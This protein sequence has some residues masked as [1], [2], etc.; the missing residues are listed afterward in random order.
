M[1]IAVALLL[2]VAC[3][4]VAGLML[5][6]GL[7]RDREIAIRIAIGAA[8]ARII[9]QILCESVPLSLVGGASDSCWL[10]WPGRWSACSA[11]TTSWRGRTSAWT[12]APGAFA[13]GVS[14]A[15]GALFGLLPAIVL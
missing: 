1:A 12:C 11:R 14:I 9:R 4:N 13:I 2:L 7:S 10:A 6:H 3:A 15:V 5:T 8:R